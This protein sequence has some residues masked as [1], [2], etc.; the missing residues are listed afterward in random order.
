[1]K[2]NSYTVKS[3]S[4]IK[5]SATQAKIIDYVYGSD[6]DGLGS[7]RDSFNN[8]QSEMD[9]SMSLKQPK[10]HKFNPTNPYI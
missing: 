7:P 1:M 9:L 4:P 5:K 8:T 6:Y 2:V 3:K 10:K